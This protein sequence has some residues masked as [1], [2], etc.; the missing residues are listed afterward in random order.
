MSERARESEI[1][2]ERSRETERESVSEG[3]IERMLE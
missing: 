3:E 2:R 1:A